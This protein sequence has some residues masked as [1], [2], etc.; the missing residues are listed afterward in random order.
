MTGA[1]LGVEVVLSA[2]PGSLGPDPAE[3]L[4]VHSRDI[5]AVEGDTGG[6]RNAI[7]LINSLERHAVD[8]VG[9]GD[10][11]QSGFQLLQKDN[12]SSPE[13][14]SEEDEDGTRGDVPPQPGGGGA[15]LLPPLERDLAV[16]RGVP[17]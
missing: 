12:S 15:G 10:Q 1:C 14:P 3:E 9:S 7:N 6:G 17:L 11:Q 13:P 2:A 8:L 4:V 5:D 16:F